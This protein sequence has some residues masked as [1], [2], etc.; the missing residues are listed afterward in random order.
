[1]ARLFPNR[2]FEDRSLQS[3]TDCA[4]IALRGK[5]CSRL[6]AEE[7]LPVVVGFVRIPFKCTEFWRIPLR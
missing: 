4:S 6:A 3:I 2:S 1:M 7:N 5:T